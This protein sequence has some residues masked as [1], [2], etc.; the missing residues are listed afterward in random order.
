MQ[1]FDPII[2]PHY[3]HFLQ[4]E[5]RSSP[6]EDVY[7]MKSYAFVCFHPLNHL[8]CVVISM[9]KLDKLQNNHNFSKLSIKT[10]ISFKIMVMYRKKL[11]HPNNKLNVT[12]FC[13]LQSFFSSQ[14]I[15]YPLLKI[16]ACPQTIIMSIQRLVPRSCICDLGLSLSNSS[17][18]VGEI[19][20]N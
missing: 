8:S 5:S 10:S 3:A 12:C 15:T 2:N 9:Y 7:I 4:G 16:Q 17:C 14:R 19:F 11:K 13:E 20:Q 1:C 6:Y 18:S